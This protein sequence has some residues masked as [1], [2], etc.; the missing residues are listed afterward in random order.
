MAK[1]EWTTTAKCSNPTEMSEPPTVSKLLEAYIQDEV[2]HALWVHRIGAKADRA[3]LSRDITHV[4]V[5]IIASRLR[6]AQG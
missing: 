4:A 5:Q 2:E 6:E 3:L 1:N